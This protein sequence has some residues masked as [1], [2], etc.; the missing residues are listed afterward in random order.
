MGIANVVRQT[1]GRDVL[2]CRLLELLNERNIVALEEN[3]AYESLA[4]ETRQRLQD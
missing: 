3:L 1:L 4:S 2:R